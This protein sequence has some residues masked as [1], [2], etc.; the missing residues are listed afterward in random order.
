MTEVKVTVAYDIVG[1]SAILAQI[2]VNQLVTV[3]FPDG[4]TVAFWGWLDKFEPG[5]LKEG[6]QPEAECVI[7]PSNHNTSGVE[8][9]PVQ[10]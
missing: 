6:E 1:W 8:V 4:K 5:A 3:H 7:V 2:G 10:A 9:A